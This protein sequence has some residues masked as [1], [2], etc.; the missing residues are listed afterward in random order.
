MKRTFQNRAK[1][2]RET[3]LRIKLFD[4]K[5]GFIGE[6]EIN[7]SSKI[8]PHAVLWATGFSC[9]QQAVNRAPITKIQ[10]QFTGFRVQ[11]RRSFGWGGEIA[12]V[13]RRNPAHPRCSNAPQGCSIEAG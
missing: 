13:G 3:N 1:R 7:P 2:V 5:K 11:P 9:K 8:L 12:Q 10:P 6:F 4:A